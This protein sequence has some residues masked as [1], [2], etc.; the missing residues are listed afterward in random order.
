[1]KLIRNGAADSAELP[2]PI[3]PPRGAPA[4]GEREQ[5][6][7]I[8]AANRARGKIAL[9]VKAS[10]GITR[11]DRLR[12][13]GPLRVRCPGPPS[14]ELEAV[15]VNTAGGLAGG[16]RVEIEVS[17]QRGARLVTTTAA[18]EKIYRSLGADAVIDA[19]LKVGAGGALAWLPQETILFD[20]ARLS[21][22][23]DIELAD[24]A[25]LV[26]VEALV[27]GRSGMGEIVRSGRLRDVWRI[28]RGGNIVHAEAMRF[29]G[30]IAAKLAQ[31]AVGNGGLGL[32]TVLISPGDEIMATAVRAL[33]PSFHGEAAASAWKGMVAARLCAADGASLRH[34]LVAILGAVGGVPLPRLW[35]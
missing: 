17:V 1:M 21:R 5:V 25:R 7:A 22:A 10:D 27:F 2:L 28:R 3:K 9:A 12:E 15:I 16:D 20:Q 23:I 31:A 13:E 33:R 26:F 32:A 34:D 35:Y 18:A 30:E 6:A 24:D 29:E 11:R 4:Y 8:F 14:R 19:H